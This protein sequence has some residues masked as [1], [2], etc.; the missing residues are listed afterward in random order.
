MSVFFFHMCFILQCTGA[1]CQDVTANLTQR[2]EV[3]QTVSFIDVSQP[4]TKVKGEAPI[5]IAKLPNDFFYPFLV[6]TAAANSCY[7]VSTVLVT[8]LSIVFARTTVSVL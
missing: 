5:F 6:Y 8:F 2:F 1:F 4:A 3:S 7:S